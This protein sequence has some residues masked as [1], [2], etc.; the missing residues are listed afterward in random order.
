M[1]LRKAIR[2]LRAMGARA[3]LIVVVIGAGTG[4]GA[5]ISL[6]LHDVERTRDDFYADYRLAD[7][8]ARMLRPLPPQRLLARGGSMPARPRPAWSSP[9]RRCCPARRP[10]PSWSG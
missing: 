9:G 10:P 2:D 1:L 3:L 8:D 4:T 6:A 5:G 7:V